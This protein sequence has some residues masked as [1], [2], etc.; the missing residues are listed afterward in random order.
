M[1][2]DKVN[3]VC[4]SIGLLL[5]ASTAAQETIR[6]TPTFSTS[7]MTIMPTSTSKSGGNGSNMGNMETWQMIAIIV[8]SVIG[9][10]T[11]LGTIL[12]CCCCPGGGMGACCPMGNNCCG[13]ASCYCEPCCQPCCD[14]PQQHTVAMPRPAPQC[15][16]AYSGTKNSCSGCQ[17]FQRGISVP[18]SLA[19]RYTSTAHVM[20]GPMYNRC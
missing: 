15:E 17:G 14:V 19:P 8:P 4:I 20:S 9:G 5:I 2:T 3:L 1:E 16:C 13:P 12:F 18:I 7:F 10:L 6:P 11:L